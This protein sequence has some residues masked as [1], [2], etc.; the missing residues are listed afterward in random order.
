MGLTAEEWR[1]EVCVEVEQLQRWPLLEACRATVGATEQVCSELRGP[2]CQ[3]LQPA[4]EGA[5]HLAE[6]S[7]P[8]PGGIRRAGSHQERAACAGC[9][10]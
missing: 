4:Q 6:K 8:E 1:W 2:L 3:C 7:L 5:G 10:G 9:L